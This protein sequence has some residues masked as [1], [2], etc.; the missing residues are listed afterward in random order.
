MS[1]PTVRPMGVGE[2]LDRAFQMLRQHFGVL[3]VTALIGTLP[4]ILFLAAALSPAAAGG[5]G[6]EGA[7]WVVVFMAT[8]AVVLIATAVV[9]GALAHQIEGAVAGRR[10]TVGYGLRNGFRVMLRLVG[11]GLA[12]YILLLLLMLPA[13]L[14]GFA[15]TMVAGLILGQGPVAVVLGGT[16]FAIPVV[17]AGIAWTAIVFLVLPVLVSEGA[18]PI[19]SLR[20]SNQ[21]AKGGRLRVFATALVAWIVIL[22]PAIGIP[23]LFGVGTALWD[24]TVAGVAG[25]TQLYLSQAVSLL[26]GAVTTPFLVAVM[27]FAYHDRRVRRDGYDLELA[28]AALVAEG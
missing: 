2:V 18:G 1:M 11:A 28:S 16:G 25:T 4:Y 21:L 23:F 19:R 27:V 8:I 17:L 3:F 15:V 9:W 12:S 20:R 10:V 5:E 13:G 6:D 24:P 26:A 14:I 7:A 22:L